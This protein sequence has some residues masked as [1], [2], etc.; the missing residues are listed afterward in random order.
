MSRI[1]DLKARLER[2]KV[3]AAQAKAALTDEE[4][5]E[6]TLR[7]QIASEAAERAKAE[8]D[9]RE[10]D[11]ERRLDAARERFP[12]DRIVSL[13]IEEAAD[14]YVVRHSGAA[15]QQW[16]KQLT[17]AATNKKIDKTQASL[18]YALASVVDWNGLDLSDDFAPAGDLAAH[19]GQEPGQVTSI[20]N[21]AAALAGAFSEARKS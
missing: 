6:I 21:A 13:L 12:G 4:R 3:A 19:L 15:Y 8:L 1:E 2:E 11:L 16:E 18:A 20:V 5:E 17:A 9:K 14:S 7:Q 10:L